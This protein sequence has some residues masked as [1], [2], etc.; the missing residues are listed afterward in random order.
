VRQVPEEQQRKARR[1]GHR[2]SPTHACPPP[3]TKRLPPE[4]DA[5]TPYA[6]PV[7]SRRAPRTAPRRW[8]AAHRYSD[9]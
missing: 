2:L 6:R 8:H 4:P 7:P 1:V 5:R 9:R 3:Y